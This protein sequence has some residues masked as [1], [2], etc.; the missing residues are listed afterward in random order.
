MPMHINIELPKS[1]FFVEFGKTQ[2]YLD[3]QKNTSPL[4]D[5]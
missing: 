1:E 2:G 5:T 4:D 3:P